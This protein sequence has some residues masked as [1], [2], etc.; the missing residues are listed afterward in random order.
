[1]PGSEPNPPP[2]AVIV[3]RI[4]S[5]P[6]VA[7]PGVA[8]PPAPTVIVEPG[9]SVYDAE[10]LTPPAPPPAAPCDEAAPPPP[11]TTRYSICIAGAAVVILELALDSNDTPLELVAFTVNVY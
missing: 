2:V 4:E 5:F 1:M 7:F 3:D 9:S 6:L 8:V 10:Y 11:A